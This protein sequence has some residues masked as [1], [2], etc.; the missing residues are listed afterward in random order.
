[1]TFVCI[2]L[3]GILAILNYSIGGRK[4][5]YPPFLFCFIW[6]AVMLS[7]I[8]FTQF[9]LEGLFPLEWDTYLLFVGGCIAATVAGYLSK[10]QSGYFGIINQSKNR[11]IEMENSLVNSKLSISIRVGLLLFCLLVF[12]LFLRYIQNEILS[13]QVENIFKSI[14]YET[15]VNEV[16][17]GWYGYVVTLSCFV[18]LYNAYSFWHKK[19]MLNRIFYIASIII[20]IAYALA[21]M[22]RSGIFMVISVNLAMYLISSSKVKLKQVVLSMVFFVLIF[23]TL[24]VVLEK[25]GSLNSSFKDNIDNSLETFA[26]YLLTP[27][28]AIDKVLHQPLI[29]HEEGKRTLRF[30]YLAGSALGLTKIHPNDFDIV[31]SFLFVPYPV[32]VYTVYNPYIRDFGWM[33]ALTWIFIFLFV[34]SNTYFKLRPGS[35]SYFSKIIY[36]LLFF[37][38]IMVFFND[39]YISL[40]STWIQFSFM[41]GGVY[42]IFWCKAK[43][44]FYYL[45]PIKRFHSTTNANL[46]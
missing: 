39:Q 29:K 27:M 6:F 40:L 7:R 10:L 25:G 37:P 22:R 31:D 46:L 19:N 34:H 43:G 33:Y 44:I 26:E 24:G 5:T 35:Y 4:I 30:F 42:F 41:T 3:F 38:L 21:T 14:R 23:L 32:N 45:F 18:S 12:P 20:A 8:V 9:Y 16:S 2:I 15:A 13:K 1:M 17:F 36:S 11:N 28:N